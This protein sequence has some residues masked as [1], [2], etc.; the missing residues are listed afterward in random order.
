[1][2]ESNLRVPHKLKKDLMIRPRNVL[3]EEQEWSKCKKWSMSNSVMSVLVV[4][5]EENKLECAIISS[6]VWSQGPMQ[7]EPKCG[8]RRYSFFSIIILKRIGEWYL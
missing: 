1:M 6:P 5:L 4:R 2:V 8:T 3:Y 7:E